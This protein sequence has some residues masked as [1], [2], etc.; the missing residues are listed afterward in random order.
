VPKPSRPKT[1]SVMAK[2]VGAACNL[3]CAYCYYLEKGELLQQG[4]SPLMSDEVLEAFIRSYI[5]SSPFESVAF[6]WQGGEPTLAGLDFFQRV[7]QLQR[8]HAFGKRVSNS[9]QTNG[10]L[11]DGEWARFLAENRFLVGLS[12]DG[13]ERLHNAHRLDK[14]GAGS[15]ARTMR[16]LEQLLRYGVGV[17]A[18]TVVS[19]ANSSYALEIYEHHKSI[20]LNFM[21]FI[22]LV[23]RVLPQGS[24]ATP[25][26]DGD[27]VVA[28]W[29]VVPEHYGTFLVGLFDEWVRKDVGR[30]FVQLF[31]VALNAWMGYDPPLCWFS[32][33]CGNAL[34]IEHNGDVYSC[35]HF[36]Y[37]ECLLGNIKT[38][39]LP[40]LAL[41]DKQ[42]DF[43][44]KKALLPQ[45]CEKC[46]VRFACNGECPKRRF[47]KSPSGEFGVNYLCPAYK[48]FYR[49]IDPYMRRMAKH[50]RS[51]RPA[52]HIM[53]DIASG[54]PL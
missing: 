19:K 4:A 35:D 18:L 12:V 11:I 32:E 16:G 39:S 6:A 53:V 48:R 33:S 14:S 41:C 2:P 46:A 50:L 42:L 17:N 25:F 43:G 10:T 24:L 51:G 20:G 9:L 34:V 3:G 5:E 13:P 45:Y 1:F 54:R 8:R 49:H 52:A 21:Q 31:D 30:V 23:E 28:P 15:Y 44:N 37:P 40:S 26:S 7:V 29:S 36:V 47:A 22:P 27:A 38:A